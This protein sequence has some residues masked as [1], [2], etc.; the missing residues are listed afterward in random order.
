M[1][2]AW[3]TQD[4]YSTHYTVY[5]AYSTRYT[6][7]YNTHYMQYSTLCIQCS[8]QDSTVNSLLHTLHSVQ[9]SR[10]YNTRC[11]QYSTHGIK[12]RTQGN[13]EHTELQTVQKASH[14]RTYCTQ[15][16]T[17]YTLHIVQY[18]LFISL[19]M[20][21]CWR[22]I[23]RLVPDQRGAD[24]W[25]GLHL[26]TARHLQVHLQDRHHLVPL[27]RPGLRDEVRQLDLRRGQGENNITT[28]TATTT[29]KCPWILKGHQSR[30]FISL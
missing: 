10:Q 29:T 26:H 16:S 18:T 9:C 23:R 17:Q 20:L 15:N 24:E 1:S 6:R 13:T 5:T 8:T 22:S 28:T 4:M 11:I 19:L 3:R 25:G 12:Y 14:Y 30:W 21:Q 2:Y 7:Q 27:R